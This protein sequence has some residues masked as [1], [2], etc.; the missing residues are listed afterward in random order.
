MATRSLRHRSSRYSSP[1]TFGEKDAAP[2]PAE[3]LSTRNGQQTSLDT[4][5]E[6][7][8]RP[9]VPSFE[10]TKGLERVGVL[11]NMQ[12]LGTAPSQRLLQKLKLNY[13][14]PSPRPAPAQ[15]EEVV[16]PVAEPE[17]VDSASP[18]DQDV[19]ATTETIEAEQPEMLSEIPSIPPRLSDAAVIS[20]PPRGRPPRRD[21]AEMPQA[22]TV[23]PSPVTLS[24][25][26]TTHVSP[27]PLSIQQQLRQDRLRVHVDRAVHE[28]HQRNTP[29]LVRGLQR[30]CDDAQLNPELWNVLEAL[31]NKSPS[32]E[33]FKVFKRYIKSGVKQHRRESQMSGSPYQTSPQIFNDLASPE[34][35][36]RSPKANHSD[37]NTPLYSEG[38]PPRINLY[39]NLPRAAATYGSEEAPVS[40]TTISRSVEVAEPGGKSI[41]HASNSSPHKRKRSGSVSTISSLSSAPSNTDEIPPPWEPQGDEPAG[42]G[43][44][45]SAGQRQ[46]AS[47]GA[48]GNRL[49]SAASAT[50]LP[51]QAVPKQS[52]PEVATSSKTNSNKKFKKSREETEFDIDELSRRK[53]HYL[54]DSFHDYNTIPRPES[55]ER[56]PVHAHPE[57][58]I[59]VDNPPPPVIHP[60]R[61]VVPTA[62]LTSLVSAQAPPDNNLANGTGRKRRYDEVDA[63]DFDET[64]PDSSSPGPLLVPPPPPGVAN[65]HP[66]GATPRATRLHP[67]Q[68]TRKSARVM[69]SPN[70]PKNG[71]IT[72]GIARAGPVRDAR[73]G[74]LNG[75]DS[76]AEDNDEF[77]AS[78]G[79][80]GKL[81]CCDG[82]TNSFHHACLEPPL[83]PDEEVEGEWF[84]PRCVA[85]RTKQVPHPSGLF[86]MVIRRV[87]DIIP[88]AYTL[89]SDI[90]DYFEGVRTGDEGEYEEVALPRT[91]N[92]TAKMNRAGFIEEPNYKETRDSKGH[93]IRCYRC[94]M[95]A[96][97]RDIIPCDFCPARWH[98][99]CIDPPL[100]VPPRRRPGDKPGASWRC[101]LHVEHDLVAVGRQTEKAP[102]ELGRVPRLRKPK[103]AVPLDVSLSR[104]F[105][106]NGIIEVELEKD[107]P[108][109]DRTKEVQMHGKIYRIPEKGIRLDFIDRVK[110][111]WYE[112]QSFPRQMD[113]P[114]R[115]RNRKYRPDGAVLHHPPQQTIVKIR[116]PDFFTGAN[117][118][119]ITET[120]KANVALRRRSIR[121]QQ[122]VLN[123]AQ[124]SQKGIDGYSGDALAELTNQL[125]SEAPADVVDAVE[126]TELDQLLELQELINRRLA[127][128]GHATHTS[129]STSMD[130]GSFNDS[131]TD[132]E[133][134]PTQDPNIDPALRW[135]PLNRPPTSSPPSSDI[136]MPI[137]PALD[138]ASA[139]DLSS[140]KMMNGDTLDVH[141]AAPEQQQPEEDEE[142]EEAR[143]APVDEAAAR[144]RA[145]EEADQ[146]W[147][148]AFFPLRT[149]SPTR[150]GP[151]NTAAQGFGNGS[152][153][154][155]METSP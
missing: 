18:M 73:I 101:P 129:R 105:R 126:Q 19:V 6:P 86:G 135:L 47:R 40:P 100:A 151:T 145:K 44:S 48:A 75:T 37:A 114:K 17:K 34:H 69:V 132:D 53:R 3:D 108:E 94:N 111:S 12:P 80:E 20:S 39:F 109:L 138:M 147:L 154:D 116:E 54:D 144:R 10:D 134:P 1:A 122:A 63:D 141:E 5:V 78:C 50:T 104:G 58:P 16:T 65:A 136:E 35:R 25:T 153:I 127:F 59:S 2:K 76:G 130:V 23:S 15:V 97:G 79:G 8:V 24:F 133:I 89:P 57:R 119:A 66:R 125:I 71:G 81:L 155:K 115:I 62:T 90:R 13:V 137:D 150:H 142:V 131:F 31:I 98:L 77:C 149:E 112:D 9:A 118:L 29:D 128:L 74:N 139:P 55:H 95:T 107:Q 43:R 41:H 92:N 27:K 103:N 14:R 21:I 102:G 91:Q 87:D 64:T 72:A 113:A 4:W 45:R 148:D 38:R 56:D 68:K 93:I 42:V 83:N 7:A 60:N 99:D 152:S 67:G 11:E 26:P 121:E 61:L 22:G 28:A 51:S 143:P 49:R 46:A 117:A 106:N 140:P 33:Q 30:I 88:K 124:M 70:K 82:C 85:R 120:A 36:E 146:R 52:Y 123:L 110:K 84:C 96:N 32:P